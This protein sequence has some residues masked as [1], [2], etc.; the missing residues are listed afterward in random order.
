MNRTMTPNDLNLAAD[1]FSG[2]VAI[3]G[4]LAATARRD[5]LRDSI[6]TIGW[7]RIEDPTDPGFATDS[8]VVVVQCRE[9]GQ[10]IHLA[11]ALGFPAGAGQAAFLLPRVGEISGVSVVI[12]RVQGSRN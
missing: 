2:A 5:H 10:A 6:V 8:A 3:S 4:V 11:N 7:Q 1:P 12:D 9:S